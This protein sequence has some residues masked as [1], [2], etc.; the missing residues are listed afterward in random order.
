VSSYSAAGII[1]TAAARAM[2]TQLSDQLNPGG[3][4]VY[5][6]VHPKAERK[7]PPR[8]VASSFG[9]ASGRNQQNQ[10]KAV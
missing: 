4:T 5:G 9:G 6:R 7:R 1:V 10:Y 3:K 8:R 2:P